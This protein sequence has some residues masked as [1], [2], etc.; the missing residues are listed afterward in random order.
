MTNTVC[1]LRGSSEE[2]EVESELQSAKHMMNHFSL[3]SCFF[4]SCIFF[5]VLAYLSNNFF[6]VQKKK[7]TNWN[8]FLFPGSAEQL[9]IILADLNVFLQFN[10][11]HNISVL[12]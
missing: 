12:L 11:L 5:L 7:S 8:S 9:M 1:F 6:F 2:Q 3:M 4:L 10:S